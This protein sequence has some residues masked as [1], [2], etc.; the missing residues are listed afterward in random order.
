MRPRILTIALAGSLVIAGG[1]GPVLAGRGGFGGFRGGSFGGYRG[2]SMGGFRG[3]SMGGFRAGGAEGFRGGSFGGARGG[4]FEG[5]SFNRSPSFGM[6]RSYGGYGGVRGGEGSNPYAAPGMS[7]R[8]G[9]FSSGPYGGRYGSGSGSGSYT[10]ARGGSV[11][12]GAAGRGAVGPGGAEA[13]RGVYG[14]SGTTAGG[15]SYGD[16][17]RVGGAAGPGGN[18]VGGRSNVGAVSGPRGTAVGGSR[19]GFAT[20]PGGSAVAGRSFGAAAVRPYGQAGAWGWHGGSYAGYHSGWVHGYWGG[21]YGGWGWGGGYGRYGYGYGNGWGWGLAGWALGSSLYSSWGYMPYANPYYNSAGVAPNVQIYNYSQP[22]D[23][24]GAPPADSVTGPAMTSFDQARDAFMKGDYNG[25]LS[26]ADQAVKAMPGDST[27][28]EFRAQVLFALGKYDD[29]AAA[30]YG[31]LSA[32]PGWDWTTLISLYPDVDTYTTQL[33]ALEAV[34]R[35][36]PNASA[37]RFVLAYL[38]LTAGQDA[39]AESEL[40]AVVALQPGDRVSAQL[41]ASLTGSKPTAPDA[42][43]PAPPVAPPAEVPNPASLV[44]SWAASPDKTSAINLTIADGGPF[45]WKVSGG[46]QSHQITGKSSFGDGV[47]TLVQSDDQAP[48]VG[49]VQWQGND[50]FL[51]QALGGGPGDPGLTFRRSP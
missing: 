6:S 31:V 35:A 47:L 38:Y 3:E 18:A 41:L 13:G 43:N 26:L 42:P 15:R 44:G 51:F 12:Y 20:G 24:S 50:A 4:G 22:I 28:H 14:V 36:S 29:A 5:S 23:T 49:K 1:T 7:T 11:N 8:S 19:E 27:L 34:V 45:T 33:R 48:M 37:A 2:G 25:A 46:G 10:T 32:G 21:H 40:K 39:D 16:V 9:E 17:G 30:L